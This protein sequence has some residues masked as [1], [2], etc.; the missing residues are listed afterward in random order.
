MRESKGAIREV[1]IIERPAPKIGSVT[2]RAVAKNEKHVAVS[3]AANSFFVP[4]S[5]LM[6]RDVEIGE[7]LSWAFRKAM[8]R[9][10]T[11]VIEE[12]D[13]KNTV[14]QSAE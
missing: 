11:A 8:H 14:R 10:T 3:A 5:T 13:V 7:R 6:E 4:P 2:G 12:G 1:P 9:L